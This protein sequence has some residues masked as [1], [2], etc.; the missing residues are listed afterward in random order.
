MPT[1]AAVFRVREDEKIWNSCRHSLPGNKI[2]HRTKV[3]R[4]EGREEGE[5]G[6]GASVCVWGGEKEKENVRGRDV[7]SLLCHVGNKV[8]HQLDHNIHHSH[9]DSTRHPPRRPQP[10]STATP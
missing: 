6:D 8:I 7:F 5:W 4:G 9:E 1:A 2:E 3:G 10:L